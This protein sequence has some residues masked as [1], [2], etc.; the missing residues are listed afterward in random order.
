MPYSSEHPPPVHIISEF[1]A[2]HSLI[3]LSPGRPGLSLR[4]EYDEYDYETATPRDYDTRANRVCCGNAR[5]HPVLRVRVSLHLSSLATDGSGRRVMVCLG[6]PFLAV[7]S[8]CS[9]V[10]SCLSLR[11]LYPLLYQWL[12]SFSWS[13]SLGQLPS[14]ICS[15]TLVSRQRCSK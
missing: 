13:C 6:A 2:G 9:C 15:S 11:Q 8:R 4:H 7:Q 3:N 5:R 12:H 10:C 14:S 1:D